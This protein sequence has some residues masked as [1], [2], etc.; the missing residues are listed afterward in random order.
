MTISLIRQSPKRSPGTDLNKASFE[1]VELEQVEPGQNALNKPGAGTLRGLL[2]YSARKAFRNPF[3]LFAA[4]SLASSLLSRFAAALPI[5]RSVQSKNFS[6]RSLSVIGAA[7]EPGVCSMRVRDF[8][9][10]GP[11]RDVGVSHDAGEHPGAW[12]VEPMH[13]LHHRPR[14]GPHH[15]LI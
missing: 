11:D 5:I 3:T 10:F 14:V 8:A 12:H 2:V 9:R 15:G 4:G 13:L 1:Q 7:G 6:S